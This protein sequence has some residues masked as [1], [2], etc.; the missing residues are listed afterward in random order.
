MK[1]FV[2]LSAIA[3]FA[4]SASA[5]CFSEKLGYPCCS[6]NNKNVV[7]T[8]SDGDWGVE[9]NNW[10]GMSTGGDCWATALGYKCCQSTSVVVETDA[11][12]KWG[13]ENN[14]WCGIVS[15]GSN[16][17][18]GRTTRTTTTTVKPSPTPA[19]PSYP[20]EL[21]NDP[22]PSKGCGKSPGIKT[23]SFQF[24]WGGRKNRL[25]HIDLPNN[26]DNNHP[27]RLVFG[28]QCMGGSG[29]NVRN[30]QY[31]GLKPLDT[32]KTTIFVA[33]EGNGQQLPWG[34]EDYQLFDELLEKLKTDLCIDESRVFSTGFSYGS[35]FSN[36]LAWDHQKVL[37]GVAVYETAA[38]NIWLPKNTGLPIAW[39]GVL[40]F[41]DGLCTPQMGRQARDVIL[42]NNSDG[43]K[44][45]NERAE[46]A[47][48]NGPHKCYE[49]KQVDQRF[50][51]KWCTQS[52]GHQWEHKD[53]GSWQT[54]VPQE[55]WDFITKF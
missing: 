17:N 53:P 41:D 55:T 33:P 42:K 19:V 34:Q 54:W 3:A 31:Y 52:G 5:A 38:V 47:Q 25:V 12:G 21:K 30:E 22:V 29:A 20:Y 2:A 40:G 35:M 26:Y 45:V 44:A 49:Y 9:N 43:G 24:Q 32:G 8:D 51:V 10:C 6:A 48:P 7:Y 14:E 37:R 39:M 36:G 16:P 50:P 15:G 11:N 18:T 1:F 13:I 46:E 23:G 4:S 27:Y 28:M